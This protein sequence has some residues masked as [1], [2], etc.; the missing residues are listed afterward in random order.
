MNVEC[1]ACVGGTNVREDMA[2][3]QEGVQVVV[4]TPGRVY[5]MINR[6]SLRTDTIKMFC[7]DEA[8]EMLS[9][10]FK[11][12]IYE[13]FQ[14]LPQDT[15]VVLLSATMP[16]DVLEVTKKF[17]R[18]PIRILVK[19]DELT[20]EGIKQFY[21]AVEKEEWKL[22]TLCDLYETVTITQA[23]IFCNTRRKVDWLTEKMH[24]R[25]FTVSAMHGDMEMKQREVLMKEFR[26]GSS[27]VLITTDLLARGI[28]VQQVS[29]VI[30]YDLPTNRENYI[31]R[32]GRGGRFGR[33][34]VAINFVTTE[35]VRMLRDIEQFYNTQI[36][37]MPLNVADL[38]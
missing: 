33:K 9:R 2:K 22:D 14:L 23:V 12:Q 31:H 13:V 29:L 38:I 18:D 25:E 1:H 35:D 17:M 19:R 15:Q 20:L 3:L 24:A 36:D 16:A 34:G 26:S 28:D 30:N 6:R 8:D 5:D 21:I 10:G 32:I 27:R 37:E 4:G 7:L 11:D